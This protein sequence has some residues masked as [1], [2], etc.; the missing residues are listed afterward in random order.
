MPQQRT[1]SYPETPKREN[2][3][4]DKA[5]TL[6]G[7]KIQRD[8]SRGGR[9]KGGKEPTHAPAPQTASGSTPPQNLTDSSTGRVPLKI[10]SFREFQLVQITACQTKS[11]PNLTLFPE[12]KP[13]KLRNCWARPRGDTYTQPNRPET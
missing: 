3:R 5:I 8:I 6:A 12:P 4:K 10:I 13:R 1:Q 9:T 7:K 11:N 2:T